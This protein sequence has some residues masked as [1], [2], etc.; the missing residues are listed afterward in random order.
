MQALKLYQLIPHVSR[1]K[2]GY[3]NRPLFP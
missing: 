3:N 2:L 1:N